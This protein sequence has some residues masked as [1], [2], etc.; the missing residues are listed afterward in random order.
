MRSWELEVHRDTE[1]S[2]FYKN[3]TSYLPLQSPEALLSAEYAKALLFPPQCYIALIPSAVPYNSSQLYSAL[4][5]Y[6][7][8]Y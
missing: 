1:N 4:Q 8:N 2:C 5:G 3:N 6:L 7:I